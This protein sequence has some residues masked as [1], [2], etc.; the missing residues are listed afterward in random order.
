MATAASRKFFPGSGATAR[1]EGSGQNKQNECPARV[2][3]WQEHGGRGAEFG[4]RSRTAPAAM[5]AIT[6]QTP[7][8]GAVRGHGR[9]TR[10]AVEIVLLAAIAAFAART[11]FLQGLVVPF[12]ISGASMAP[13]LLGAHRQ[14]VCG[15][16]RARF[17]CDTELVPRGAWAVCPNCA[18]GRNDPAEGL[19]VAGDRLMVDRLAFQI[20]TPRRWE[21]IALREPNHASRLLVKR[22]VGLPGET[23]A[24]RHGDVYVNGRI[25]RKSLE[26]QKSMGIVVHDASRP[27]RLDPAR[28]SHWESLRPESAW[29]IH[30]GTFEHPGGTDDWD[31]LDYRHVQSRGDPLQ[32]PLRGSAVLDSPRYSPPRRP[33]EANHVVRDLLLSFRLAAASG[34]GKLAV[35]RAA[36]RSSRSRCA[37]RWANRD[38]PRRPIATGR[39]A[40]ASPRRLERKPGRCILGR[41][42]VAGCRRRPT[43]RGISFRGGP[44]RARRDRAAVFPR[45]CGAGRAARRRRDPQRPLLRVAKLPRR[46]DRD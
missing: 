19:A 26:L 38:S 15:D 20:R 5:D 25:V 8:A 29:S 33:G 30:D 23:V 22:V 43:L 12:Q 45:R 44:A 7:R 11:W 27:A 42:P 37:A 4:A 13:T 18:Y 31:W 6:R 9:R 17:D 46:S 3:H 28:S 32:G 2:P 36:G 34:P 1:T 10:R 39:R 41:S 35:C 40:V 14:L 16:C 21:V 24:L